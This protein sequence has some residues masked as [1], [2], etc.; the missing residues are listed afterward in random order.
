MIRFFSQEKNYLPIMFVFLFT[1]QSYN[2]PCSR[3]KAMFIIRLQTIVQV[4]DKKTHKHD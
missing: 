2:S 1:Y 3:C 4:Y